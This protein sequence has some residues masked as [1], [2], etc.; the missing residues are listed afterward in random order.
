MVVY[1]LLYATMEIINGKLGR[2]DDVPSKIYSDRLE[3]YHEGKLHRKNGYPAVSYHD[4]RKEY[5][6]NGVNQST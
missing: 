1:L 4:G 3:W 5:Y 2:Q 6:I